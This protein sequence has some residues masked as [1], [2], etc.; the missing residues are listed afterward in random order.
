MHTAI[1]MPHTPA[2]LLSLSWMMVIL[3][4][5]VCKSFFQWPL[6]HLS[7]FKRLHLGND[8]CFPFQLLNLNFDSAWEGPRGSDKPE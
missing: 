7:T 6:I 8:A 1:L 3:I 2:H 4:L 5:K